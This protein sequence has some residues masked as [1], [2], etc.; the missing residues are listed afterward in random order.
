MKAIQIQKTGVCGVLEYVDMETPNPAP[1]QVLI[2]VES[3]SVNFADTMV[4]RGTYAPMPKLPAILG[5]ECS[6][7]VKTLGDGVSQFFQGLPVAFMGPNCYA[8][9]VVADAGS[10]IPLP[11][12]IDMDAAAA[13]PINYLTAYHILHTMARIR[14]D[15]TVLTHVAAGGVGVAVAQLGKLAKITTIGLTSTDEKVEFAKIDWNP[16]GLSDKEKDSALYL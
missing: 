2:K 8:E 15:E 9:Y 16:A 3:I 13:F 1:G 10:L 6:G 11:D 7:Y 4:R 14:P 12:G 5:M